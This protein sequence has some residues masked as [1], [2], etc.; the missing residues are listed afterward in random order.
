VKFNAGFVDDVKI[1]LR[2]EKCE[3]ESDTVLMVRNEI[4]EYR[5]GGNEY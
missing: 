4:F 2:N 5:I 1:T 3:D